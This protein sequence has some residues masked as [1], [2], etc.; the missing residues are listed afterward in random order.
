MNEVLTQGPLVMFRTTAALLAS[1]AVLAGAPAL[2]APVADASGAGQGLVVSGDGD[3][4]VTFTGRQGSHT[5]QLYLVR[6]GQDDL[7]LFDGQA[8]AEGD[9]VSLGALGAGT[10]LVFRL[11]V[12][13]G[14][15]G[16]FDLFT[17]AG[18]LNPRGFAN[19]RA[20]TMGAGLAM[21]SFED[22]WGGGDLDFDDFGFNV[23]GAEAGPML[24]N[25]VPGAAVL[26]LTAIGGLVAARRRR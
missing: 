15:G 18:T 9:A 11:A 10:D 14:G 20:V 3:V 17:G 7:L 19:A 12:T 22:M 21:I 5:K 4:T 1:L 8:S 24:A 23:S 6:E 2:A 13:D 26:M 16:Q 25:P